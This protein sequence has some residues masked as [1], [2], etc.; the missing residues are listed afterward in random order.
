[1][2]MEERSNRT[3]HFAQR[4]FH[5]ES[6]SRFSLSVHAT[7]RPRYISFTF[8]ITS[9]QYHQTDKGKVYSVGFRGFS[10]FRDYIELHSRRTEL[11]SA[12]YSSERYLKIIVS[13]KGY[14]ISEA[15]LCSLLIKE[16]RK[17]FIGY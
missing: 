7:S 15:R 3:G 16:I 5:R 17:L 12:I 6:S 4:I 14:L 8:T 2:R 11:C 1:M 9:L 10:I 13:N